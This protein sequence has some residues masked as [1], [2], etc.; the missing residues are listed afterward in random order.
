MQQIGFSIQVPFIPK[1]DDPVRLLF[2][3]TEGLDYT[4]LYKTYS[5]LGRNPA[6]D[7]VTLFR[8]LIYGDMNKIYSSRLK[9]DYVFKRF[10]FR[11]KKNVLVEF[12][13]LAF[14]YNIQKLFNKNI[15]NTN[16]I[17]LHIPK[18]A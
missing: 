1:E 3:V 8:I 13:L 14:A 9:Q 18:T 4:N 10:L 11:G 2:E 17:L 12:T 6:V 16:G 15:K 5:T 7:P